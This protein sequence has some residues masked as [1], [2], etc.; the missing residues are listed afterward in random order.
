MLGDH[1]GLGRLRADFAA[2][3]QTGSFSKAFDLITQRQ[4]FEAGS[5]RNLVIGTASV[6]LFKSFMSQYRQD[7][8]LGTAT[9]GQ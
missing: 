5:L 9:P 2:G 7:F 1:T 8:G 4:A 3:M 6:N